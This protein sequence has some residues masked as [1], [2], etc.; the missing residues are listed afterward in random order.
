LIH[1]VWE[2]RVRAG[3]ERDFESRVHLGTF[4]LLS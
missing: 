1:V 3:M 4:E 2:F